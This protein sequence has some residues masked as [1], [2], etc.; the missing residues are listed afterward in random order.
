M[1]FGTLLLCLPLSAVAAESCPPS[2]GTEGVLIGWVTDVRETTQFGANVETATTRVEAFRL[3]AA[4]RGTSISETSGGSI[5][6]GQDFWLAVAPNEKPVQLASVSSFLDH[7]GEDHCVYF[8]T[9]SNPKLPQWT[10][11][12]SK[13]MAGVFRA[14]S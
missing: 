13:P 3:V 7:M 2:K 11:L 8:G 14:P 6:K 10:L 12:T 1:R 9:L 5:T 4:L